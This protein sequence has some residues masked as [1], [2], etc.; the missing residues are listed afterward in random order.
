LVNEDT[1]RTARETAS[2]STGTPNWTNDALALKTTSSPLRAS[3]TNS[4]KA[5]AA[6]DGLDQ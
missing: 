6:V 4:T 2:H 3:F 1:V 5:R